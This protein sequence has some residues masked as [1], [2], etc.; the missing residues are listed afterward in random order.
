MHRSLARY[1]APVSFVHTPFWAD[2]ITTMVGFKFSVQ[3]G[4]DPAGATTDPLLQA[5]AGASSTSV[6]NSDGSTN[7]LIT[8][9]TARR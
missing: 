7:H 2:F 5:L 8:Y 6:G 3:T 4:S 1:S 9:A